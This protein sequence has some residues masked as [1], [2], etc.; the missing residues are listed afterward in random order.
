MARCNDL[1][2]STSA[3]PAPRTATATPSMCRQF[4]LGAT[5]KCTK[6]VHRGDAGHRLPAR[7]RRGCARRTSTASSESPPPAGERA[8]PCAYGVVAAR[9]A[10]LALACRSLSGR[11]R[12]V[13]IVLASRRSWAAVAR[14]QRAAKRQR[15][16]RHRRRRRGRRRR[17]R[18]RRRRR[19]AAAPV[20]RRRWRRRRR[21]RAVA[22]R[23]RDDHRHHQRLHAWRPPR[24]SSPS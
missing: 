20:D 1:G 22:E 14:C 6:L 2:P 9:F 17:H 19:H 16:R 7:R 18:R 11:M 8:S 5:Q 23:D 12:I 13:A 3:T 10:D 15:R 21:D 4:S 24:A